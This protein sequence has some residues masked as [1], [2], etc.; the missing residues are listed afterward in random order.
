MTDTPHNLTPEE[1]K[2]LED[3]FFELAADP[4]AEQP[5]SP[6]DSELQKGLRYLVFGVV[7]YAKVDFQP[8][9][10]QTTDNLVDRLMPFIKSRE[11]QAR[12]ESG[13]AIARVFLTLLEQN[14]LLSELGEGVLEELSQT[15]QK[16]LPYDQP[17]PKSDL[18]PERKVV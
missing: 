14:G 12:K 15:N 6:E 10:I 2:V 16:K 7:S 17:H 9:A 5:T 8:N 1:H 11:E 13:M 4:S 3:N 18:W